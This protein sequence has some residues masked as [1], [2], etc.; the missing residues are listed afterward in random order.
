M[1]HNSPAATPALITSPPTILTSSVRHRIFLYL[2][3]LIILLAFGA[4]SGGLIEIPIS[5]LLKNKLSLTANE[6]AEFRLPRSRSICPL[7]SG[8][9]AIAGI[10]L[11]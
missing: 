1:P 5:F 6:L 3:A 2:G 10:P 11:G 4:P 7:C 9:S 8:S